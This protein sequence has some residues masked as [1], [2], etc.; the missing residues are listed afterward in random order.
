MRFSFFAICVLA[1]SSLSVEAL[2]I[3]NN[4]TTTDPAKNGLPAGKSP[5]AGATLT[6]AKTGEVKDAS[7]AITQKAEQ[8]KVKKAASDAD[9]DKKRA[10][11]Q[12]Q[13]ARKKA[14]EATKKA[15]EAAENAK[16]KIPKAEAANMVKA[17][18]QKKKGP[19]GEK[20][21]CSYNKSCSTEL[22]KAKKDITDIKS[23]L[24]EAGK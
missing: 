13:E 11:E 1:M 14:A 4:Q 22:A 16:K 10:D 21:V 15:D 23:K 8:E 2:N 18:D 19:D 20:N 7:A 5:V 17:E 12:V 6:N 24:R 3:S 9:A